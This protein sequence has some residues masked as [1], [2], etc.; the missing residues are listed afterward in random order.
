[1]TPRVQ[2]DAGFDHRVSGSASEWQTNLGVS[3]YFG[4]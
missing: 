2:I 1:V 3:I 4:R